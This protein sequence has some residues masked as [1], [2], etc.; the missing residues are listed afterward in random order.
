[1]SIA[2]GREV[3]H[4]LPQLRRGRTTVLGQRTST[5]PSG[6]RARCRTRGRTSA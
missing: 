1:M 6:G 3:E 4:R 5:S 2:R